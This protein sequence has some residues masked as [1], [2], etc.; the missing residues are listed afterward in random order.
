MQRSRK[1]LLAHVLWLGGS[2]CSGKSS[3]ARLLA[4]GGQLRTYHCDDEFP[5]HQQRLTPRQ[6]PTMHKWTITA[7]DE[8]WMQPPGILLDEAISAYREHLSLVVDDLLALPGPTPILAEG[9][10]LL[11]GDVH[12]LLSRPEQAIWLVPTEGFQRSHYPDRGSW[13]QDILNQCEQPEQA[14]Q[15]WMDRDVAFARW[16]EQSAGELGLRLVRVDGKR[17]IA[18]NAQLVARH[19]GL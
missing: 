4:T 13:V 19:F 6:Q 10:C 12:A 3:I 16:V 18:E 9:T 11:P 8:L 7:W 2:P 1:E 14:L 15:N 5:K 17:S